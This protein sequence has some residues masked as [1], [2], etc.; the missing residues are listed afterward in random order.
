M[1]PHGGLSES[2]TSARLTVLGSEFKRRSSEDEPD[3]EGAIEVEG[4]ISVDSDDPSVTVRLKMR[5]TA[6]SVAGEID[7][8]LLYQWSDSKPTRAEMIEFARTFG[9]SNALPATAALFG[10]GF[11]RFGVRMSFPPPHMAERV[12]EILIADVIKNE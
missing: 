9:V 5:H 8:S 1:N 11:L 7:A 3:G 2:L 12:T 4:R 6:N 10:E